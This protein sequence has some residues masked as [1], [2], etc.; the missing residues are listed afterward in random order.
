ML[1]IFVASFQYSE[2]KYEKT[3]KNELIIKPLHC[4]H[5]QI[6]HQQVPAKISLC[7]KL[8][9][10]AYGLSSLQETEYNSHFISE[11]YLYS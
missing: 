10:S 2:H 8:G 1:W 11:N 6:L 9:T 5:R 3:S 4:Q 7:S